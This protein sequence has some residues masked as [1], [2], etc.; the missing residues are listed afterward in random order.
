MN[1]KVWR[2]YM[3]RSRD[4][5]LTWSDA[6]PMEP[7]IVGPAKNPPIIL[8]DGTIMSP[9]SDENRDWTSH[10]EVSHDGGYRWKRQPSLHFNGGIIQ[11]AIFQT[12]DGVIRMVHSPTPSPLICWPS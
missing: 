7:G 3:M 11:P 4:G 8:S 10:V 6:E 9:S 12:H 2:G 1:P 5:G